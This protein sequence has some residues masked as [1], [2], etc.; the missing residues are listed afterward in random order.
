MDPVIHRL[1]SASGRRIH[2]TGQEDTGYPLLW[3]QESN[4]TP[5][6]PLTRGIP[7]EI[8]LPPPKRS[9]VVP[10]VGRAEGFDH[11]G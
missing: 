11:P 4:D 6:L 5:M 2:L 3:N 10:V 1:L 7:I 9:A 8:P